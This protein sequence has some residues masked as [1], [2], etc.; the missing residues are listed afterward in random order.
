MNLNYPQTLNRYAYV[1]NNPLGYT[2]PTGLEPVCIGANCGKPAPP[3]DP[4]KNSDDDE[5]SWYD[6]RSWFGIP[7]HP[8][9]NGTTKPRPIKP[10]ANPTLTAA[11]TTAQQQI[12]TAQGYIAGGKLAGNALGVGSPGSGILGPLGSGVGSL[13]GYYTAVRTGG[14]NDIKNQPGPG[15]Q[16]QVGIDAGNISYGITCPFGASACQ[17]AAGLA[18][19]FGKDHNP[20][21]ASSYFDTPGD[22]AS[23]RQGQAMR[24][25]GCHE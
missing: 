23:I 17:L 25:A 21:P 11:G 2:D 24:A 13:Y 15:Y 9:F 3:D 20:G 14:P 22:N 18:Q 7:R 4:K 12:A 8:S 16:N 5:Y 1:G 10:C 6:P 19:T